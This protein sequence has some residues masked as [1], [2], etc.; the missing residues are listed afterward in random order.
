[1]RLVAQ[2]LAIEFQHLDQLGNY[3]SFLECE[4][5]PKLLSIK[6]NQMGLILRMRERHIE[7]DE[8][9]KISTVTGKLG[10]FFWSVN[11]LL[12]STTLL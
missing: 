7:R 1:V 12:Y 10:R 9:F 6:F 4:Y 2:P 11:I 8:L 3:G 5:T